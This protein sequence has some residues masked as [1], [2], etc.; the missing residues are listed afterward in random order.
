MSEELH[1]SFKATIP[2]ARER[3][4]SPPRLLS[5]LSL[6]IQANGWNRTPL[7]PPL[8]WIC[9]AGA[10][11]LTSLLCLRLGLNYPTTA[12][13]FLVIIA[14]LALFGSLVTSMVF[15]AAALVCLG[16]FFVEPA[17]TFDASNLQDVA[18]LVAFLLSSLFVTS[19]IWR[20][21][22]LGAIH[23]EQAQ[24][25]DLTTDAI[26]VRDQNDLITYWNRGAEELYGW[27][28]AEAMGHAEHLLLRTVFPA[29]FAELQADAAA[30]RKMGGRTD[31]HDAQ[32]STGFGPQPLVENSRRAD[33]WHHR[34]QH[35]CDATLPCR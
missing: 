23:R 1:P 12:F 2:P 18:A 30:D 29:P 8:F 16:Y 7:A 24:L 31:P 22:T 32:R 33:I 19:L 11:A 13:A 10:L 34:K 3:E 6:P 17:F 15:S 26:I 4:L 9:G 25:L 27:K 21:R 5:G 28:R 14:V 35:R 20:V